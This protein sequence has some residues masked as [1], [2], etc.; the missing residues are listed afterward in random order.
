[1]HSKST[2][3]LAALPLILAKPALA[4]IEY[5][6][7]NQG[8]H[9]VDLTAAGMTESTVQ[10]GQTPAEL[11]ALNGPP[12]AD[13]IGG[14]GL[15]PQAD[16][17][18]NDTNLWNSTYQITNNV[19]IFSG[20]TY[21]STSSTATVD[22]NDVNDDAWG[23]GTEAILGDSHKVDFFNFRLSQTSS[24]TITWNV[25]FG[26]GNFL[27]CAF[28][29]YRGVLPYQG[30]DDA[31]EIMNPV[32]A[33]GGGGTVK[34]QD[35]LDDGTRR[36][37]QGILSPFR[38]TGPGAPQYPGQFS[39][40]ANWSQ[41]SP[42]GHWSA[43]EFIT[44]VNAKLTALT[45]AEADTLETLTITLP[46]GNYTIAASGALGIPGSGDSFALSN[47]HGRMT[48]SAAAVDAALD[49]FAFTDATN[50]AP[51]ALTISNSITVS[52]I[53]GSEVL[54]LIRVSGDAS[55]EYAINGGAFTGAAGTVRNGD[56]IVVRHQSATGSGVSVHTVLDIA[57]VS[58]TF[59]S[60]TTGGGGAPDTTPDSFSF[61]VVWNVQPGTVQVSNAITVSGIGSA[62]PVSIMGGEYSINGGAY[63][64]ADGMADA[65][66]QITVRHTSSAARDAA[67]HS[68]LTIGGVSD[69]FTSITEAPDGGRDAS[70]GTSALDGW[71]LALLGVLAGL[72]RRVKRGQS[73]GASASG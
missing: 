39:A 12:P 6:D 30:H 5:Y 15:S 68:T 23:N 38:D 1:M 4:H 60:T 73:A 37:V 43:I 27:D 17:P 26:A 20:V 64:S 18:L 49:P 59:T 44:A 8:T 2:F 10:Y 21:T 40:L 3:A 32:E 11:L 24:V 48:Y 7:L 53:G 63:T 58:D 57:G 51:G 14:A 65:N 69:T 34:V 67:T 55:S 47:L 28:S 56:M 22:V 36:D 16:M 42:A 54:A 31:V 29:L 70:G 71:T 13:G 9:V 72:R 66:D 41:A 35:V 46:A 52:G 19:G 25:D 33:V 45:A 62:T 50:V 61:D